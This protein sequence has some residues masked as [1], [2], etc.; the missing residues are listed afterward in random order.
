M[1]QSHHYIKISLNNFTKTPTGGDSK[2]V[3]MG[4]GG[5]G[6]GVGVGTLNLFQKY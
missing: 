6:G 3:C 1:L 2:G 4:G 5:G